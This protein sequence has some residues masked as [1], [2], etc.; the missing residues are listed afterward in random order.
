MK[1]RLTPEQWG[2][3]IGVSRGLVYLWIVR[4]RIKPTLVGGH[5]DCFECKRPENLPAG[6]KAAIPGCALKNKKGM[7]ILA[8]RSGSWEG[9]AC[10]QEGECL[11]SNDC[12][13]FKFMRTKDG[14]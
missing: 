2:K 11:N 5:W 4:G 10:S 14:K 3:Q 9:L 12:D 1:P 13:S 8:L 7:C 6:R